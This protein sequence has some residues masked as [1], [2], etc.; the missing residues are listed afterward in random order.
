MEAYTTRILF[1]QNR[2][3]SVRMLLLG[4]AWFAVVFGVLGRSILGGLWVVFGGKAICI[5]AIFSV[6]GAATADSLF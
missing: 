5:G 3:I 4:V 2:T 1:G 6:I